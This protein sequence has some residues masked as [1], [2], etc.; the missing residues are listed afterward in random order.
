[1]EIGKSYRKKPLRYIY[2][3]Y[4]FLLAYIVAALV[5]WF[6]SLNQQNVLISQ[7][8]EQLLQQDEISHSETVAKIETERKKKVVQYLGEGLTFFILIIAGAV[9]VFRM[10]RRQLKFSAQQQD[11]MMAITHE[12]KTPIAVTRLNLETLL[13]HSLPLARQQRLISSTLREADRLNALSNNMILLN[14]MDMGGYEINKELVDLG[15]LAE[16]CKEE[17]QKRFPDRQIESSTQAQGII[18]G[19]EVMIRLAINNLLDNAVKYSAV[20]SKITLELGKEHGKTILRVKD[21]GQGVPEEEKEKIFEKYFRGAQAR[22]KGTG[23]G[24]Y[25]TKKIIQQNNGIIRLSDNR[26]S[27][28]IFALHFNEQ[29]INNK[30]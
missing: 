5:F 14:Q 18:W 13:K 27:G 10:I 6:I 26:P 7:Y 17:F 22:A 1:M 20:E 8:K 2:I 30:K 19:D 16:E 15:E 28:S 24:L 29:K 9:I 4:W 12:L 23:L 11:F 3:F 25:V 21:Q